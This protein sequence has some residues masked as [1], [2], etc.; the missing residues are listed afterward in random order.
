MDQSVESVVAGHICLDVT[1]AF[2]VGGRSV[3]DILRPGCLVQVGGAVVSTGGPVSNTGFPMRRM[4]VNVRL[5][6]KCGDDMFGRALLEKIR[7]E[8]PGA[9]SG[10]R[11]VPGEETSY[12]VVVNPPGIDRIF[13]HCHGANDTFAAA[14]IDLATVAQARLFHFGYPPLMA[15][16]YGDGGRELVEIFRQVKATGAT[17]S[18]DMA[19]PDPRSPAGAAD[20]T[21]I[22]ERTLPF[23]DV[24]TPSVEE[25][26]FML[27]REKFD[28][29]SARAGDLD[30]ELLSLI[31]GELLSDLGQQCLKMG[32]AVVLIKCG[33]YG[34]YIASA[35]AERFARGVG[36]GMNAS[37]A[38][39]STG[40]P[41]VSRMGVSPMQTL[42][43]EQTSTLRQD[44]NEPATPCDHHGQDARG[45]HG[46]DARATGAASWI[47]RE[48]FEP[49]YR[50]ENVVSA[51]GAG[52]CAIAA[53]L[54]S[55]LRDCRLEDAVRN[56]CA[57][58]AQN[59]TVADTI[60]GVKTWEQTLAQVASRPE[61]YQVP[62]PLIRFRYDEAE[63]HYVGPNDKR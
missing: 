4:G 7:A 55:C 58:G 26:I 41:P 27:R 59:V 20:W 56:A 12:T 23:V 40:V 57:V 11:I 32:A 62:L 43:T 15:R 54:T 39:S 34:M 6:G 44:A 14:D 2:R 31:D 25:L 13:L 16:M 37:S 50:V 52:D 28:E 22:L 36:R 3:G 61:K 53:F 48:L 35:G 8:A 46:R 1:P 51:T 38:A 49:G 33:W 24:F 9:E 45:T 60:S 30:L 10:M 63:E 21:S 19:Y 42:P 29:L 17:T 47:G 18:L 5:M